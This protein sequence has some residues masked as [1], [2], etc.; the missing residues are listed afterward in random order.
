MAPSSGHIKKTDTGSQVEVV[1]GTLGDPH[2][3]VEIA[4]KIKAKA[5]GK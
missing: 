4:E 2:M 1:V 5:E 3:G